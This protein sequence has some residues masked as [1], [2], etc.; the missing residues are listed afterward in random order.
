MLAFLS[1]GVVRLMNLRGSHRVRFIDT[2]MRN[3]ANSPNKFL[4]QVL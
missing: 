1:L 4:S 3:I 2:K